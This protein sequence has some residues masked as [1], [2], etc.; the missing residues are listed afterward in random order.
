[1]SLHEELS[2]SGLRNREAL[3]QK[4]LLILNDRERKV[5]FLR[6]WSP[7][8]I[9]EISEI[10]TMTWDETDRF[11]EFTLQKLKRKILALENGEEGV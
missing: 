9:Q 3:L 1:M 7:N 8:S 10:L 4:A 11:I 6:F 2:L 5:I